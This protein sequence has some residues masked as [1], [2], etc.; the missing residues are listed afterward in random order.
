[1]LS[2]KTTASYK[3]VFNRVSLVPIPY[4]IYLSSLPLKILFH[5]LYMWSISPERERADLR[6]RN[7]RKLPNLR[8]LR[9]PTSGPR[10]LATPKLQLP[11]LGQLEIRL[12]LAPWQRMRLWTPLQRV[13][14][15]SSKL[16]HIVSG[17]IP[18]SMA[19][20]VTQ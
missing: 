13:T 4:R 10:N 11:S 20:T 9:S 19:N 2:P 14:G 17:Q 15:L 12:E 16:C 8:N 3:V 5:R 18:T 6:N 1:M 7:L